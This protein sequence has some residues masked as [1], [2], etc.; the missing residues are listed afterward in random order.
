[1]LL[2]TAGLTSAVLVALFARTPSPRVGLVL[3]LLA[4]SGLEYVAGARGGFPLLLSALVLRDARYFRSI[5]TPRLLALVAIT[6]GYVL[7]RSPD[8]FGFPVVAGIGLLVYLAALTPWLPQ[9]RCLAMASFTAILGFLGARIVGAQSNYFTYVGGRLVEV[10]R[11]VLEG[12][13]PNARAAGYLLGLGLALATLEGRRAIRYQL[14]GSLA[15]L[16]MSVGVASTGSRTGI[17]GAVLLGLS[18]V[19]YTSATPGRKLLSTLAAGAAG[20]IGYQ[21]LA[22]TNLISRF[23]SLDRGAGIRLGRWGTSLDVALE[24][25]VSLLFGSGSGTFTRTAATAPHNTLLEAFVGFG[26]VGVILLGA[27]TTYVARR[28]LRHGSR[29]LATTGWVIAMS[30]LTIGT[31][32]IYLAWVSLAL[33]LGAGLPTSS[34]DVGASGP[35]RD[36]RKGW[37]GGVLR[38]P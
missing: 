2:I 35:T 22:S 29:M 27:T 1:M 15:A 38:T 13:D 14:F 20:L 7:Q 6:S 36:G 12:T 25:P 10:T 31:L 11:N 4:G 16:I 21:V 32:G 8:T 28:T 3:G 24:S 5:L 18:A 23:S 19:L 9:S 26:V 34:R 17:A 30:A 33:I 37:H